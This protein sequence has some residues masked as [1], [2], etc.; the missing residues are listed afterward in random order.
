MDDDYTENLWDFVTRIGTP[1]ILDTYLVCSKTAQYFTLGGDDETGTNY[2]LNGDG[3]D[4]T[5]PFKNK[6][7]FITAAELY[8]PTAGSCSLG[9]VTFDNIAILNQFGPVAG[10]ASLMLAGYGN[11]GA[12]VA[13][14]QGPTLAQRYNN[15]ALKVRRRI[16]IA[17]PT[18]DQITNGGAWSHIR[19]WGF[20]IDRKY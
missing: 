8:A 9:I 6:M 19:L 12:A 10:G 4:D 13:V 15:T 5:A 18:S 3:T 2:D 7:L 11:P 16:G 1:F 17:A 20:Y 14:A